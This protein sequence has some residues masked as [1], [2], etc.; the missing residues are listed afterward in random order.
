MSTRVTVSE[1]G[2]AGFATWFDSDGA[3]ALSVLDDV[4]EEER[5]CGVAGLLARVVGEGLGPS[6]W[7]GVTPELVVVELRGAE[8][9]LG[10]G[11]S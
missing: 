4:A 5:A 8:Q 2:A 3:A 1:T 9:G 7:D 11:S 6:T 10:S